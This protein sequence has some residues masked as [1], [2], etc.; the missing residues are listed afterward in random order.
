MRTGARRQVVL[1]ALAG[2]LLAVVLCLADMARTSDVLGGLVAASPDQPASR[3]LLEDFPEEPLHPGGAHDGQF[4]YVIAREGLQPAA[5]AP[6]LDRARYRLQRI[7]LP[8]AGWLLHP[9][10]GGPGLLWS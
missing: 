10:G 9:T 8:A 5:S 1:W 6:Y 3:V 2:T 7:G 4:Y